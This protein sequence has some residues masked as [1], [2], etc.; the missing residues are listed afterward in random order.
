M[1]SD[2]HVG[3][4][5]IHTADFYQIFFNTVDDS[6]FVVDAA[7][8]TIVEANAQA[9]NVTDFQ[10]EELRGLAFDRLFR[11]QEGTFVFLEPVDKAKRSSRNELLL[12]K[13]DGKA[14]KMTVS[15][16]WA[17]WNLTK[18]L[19]L[20]ARESDTTLTCGCS[21]AENSDGSWSEQKD[22]PTI[23]GQSEKIRDV[24]RLIGAVAK[25]D[26]TV[27][28]QGESGTGKEIIANAIHMHSHRGRD[29]FVKVNCAAL[30]ETLLESELFGHVKGAFTGAICERRGRFKQADGGTILLDEIGSMS[31]SGQ[32]KLLRVLQEHEFEP[33]GSSVTIPVNVRV[34]ASTNIDLAK[35]ASEGK[36]REDLYY[37]LNVFSIPLPPLRE[38]KEDIL[39]LVQHFLG[40]HRRAPGT[41][42]QAVAPQTHALLVDHDWPGNVRELEN[43][44]EHAIIVEKGPVI[45]P[46]SLPMNLAKSGPA[47]DDSELTAEMGL[48]EKLILLERQIILDTLLRAHGVKKN[49][50]TMLGIDARNLPYLLRKHRVCGESG[51][52]S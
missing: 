22:F 50:A 45:L 21:A 18:Y 20:S 33:V 5:M 51:F 47:R 19:F 3:G 1:D 14:V 8:R 7:A 9:I 27:L 39:L 11:S 44:M 17:E 43:A 26:A 36:F 40:R 13:K 31:L 2:N 38:R 30:T 23:I 42:I 49:T 52:T 6:I 4:T 16:A 15:A 24:C 28:I 34:V 46:S 35:A 10:P 29:P 25:S 37:R 41:E 12:V 32:A 48:R